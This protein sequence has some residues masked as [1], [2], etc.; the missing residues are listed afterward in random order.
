MLWSPILSHSENRHM[1]DAAPALLSEAG[2]APILE[3]NTGHF[4]AIWGMQD[5]SP[6]S[7]PPRECTRRSTR[8]K[9]CGGRR[10]C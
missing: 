6:G 9:H 4:W 3:A 10:R 5:S 8:E 7:A 1:P 2:Y